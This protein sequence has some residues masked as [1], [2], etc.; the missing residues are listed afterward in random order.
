MGE[1]RKT[2]ILGSPDYETIGFLIVSTGL[3]G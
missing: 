1:W 3:F 2:G